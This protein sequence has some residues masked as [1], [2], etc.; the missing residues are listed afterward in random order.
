MEYCEKLQYSLTLSTTKWE[1]PSVKQICQKMDYIQDDII[2]LQ[3][4][5]YY[6]TG[7]KKL[8]IQSILLQNKKLDIMQNRIF[9]C[10]KYLFETVSTRRL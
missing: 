1:Y 5:E 10:N 7:V 4:R 6:T 2:Q 3:L 9:R 8:Q